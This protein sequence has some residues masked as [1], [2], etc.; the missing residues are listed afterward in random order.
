VYNDYYSGGPTDRLYVNAP[1]V[2]IF[3]WVQQH[4]TVRRI[5]RLR[6]DFSDATPG[7]MRIIYSIG[8]E[9]FNEDVN[10]EAV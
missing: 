6:T 3:N 1:L 8:D 5:S 4:D 10:L 9:F 2:V 7:L